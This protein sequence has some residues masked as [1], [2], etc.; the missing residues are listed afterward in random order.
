MSPLAGEPVADMMETAEWDQFRIS[1]EI[2]LKGPSE[3]DRK[4]RAHIKRRVTITRSNLASMTAM[5]G[6]G[7]SDVK[8]GNEGDK[9]VSF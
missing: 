1:R 6:L 7:K 4:E 9:K 8:E 2:L 5:L 3:Y